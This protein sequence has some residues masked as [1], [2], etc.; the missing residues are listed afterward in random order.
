MSPYCFEMEGIW[1]NPPGLFCPSDKIVVPPTLPTCK[2]AVQCECFSQTSNV[3]NKSRKTMTPSNTYAIKAR[4][5]L[6]FI[7]YQGKCQKIF[8]IIEKILAEI[9][10]FDAKK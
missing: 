4:Q 2:Y 7:I 6:F 3:T 9:H 8:L 10:I 5:G 1:G